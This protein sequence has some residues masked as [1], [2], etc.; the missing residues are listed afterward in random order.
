MPDVK[1]DGRE[2]WLRFEAKSLS[3]CPPPNEILNLVGRVHRD[4]NPAAVESEVAIE[5]PAAQFSSPSRF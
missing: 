3:S 5:A 1:F 2:I 4:K